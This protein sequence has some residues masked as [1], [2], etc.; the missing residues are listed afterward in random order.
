[1][2]KIIFLIILSGFYFPS[3]SA[4][5]TTKNHGYAYTL[6]NYFANRKSQYTQYQSSPRSISLY[7]GASI[8]RETKED[9][10]F[11]VTSMI[12]G[13]EQR[14]REIPAVADI[15]LQ[16]GLQIS[17]TDDDKTSV[18]IEVIPRLMFP[19]IRSGFPFYVGFGGGFGFYPKN[20]IKELPAISFNGQAF[21]G[22]RIVDLY[23]NLG[24]KGEVSLRLQTPFNKIE[25]YMDVLGSAGL[26][27]SF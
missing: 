2:K 10:I 20:I 26:V 21:A 14:V 1:M 16:I 25:S 3:F 27:F 12:L 24:I 4:E 9:T 22:V 11:P 5:A 15:N 19:D 17:K 18:A 13:L 7:A 8:I 6:K 23:H